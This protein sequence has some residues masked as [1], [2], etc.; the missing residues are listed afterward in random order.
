M[1]R[2]GRRAGRTFVAL[3]PIAFTEK[4]VRSFLRYQLTAYPFADA[5]PLHGS[6]VTVPATAKHQPDDGALR[7]HNEHVFRAG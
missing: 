2:R 4:V 3:N 5:R 1:E 6:V 7:W